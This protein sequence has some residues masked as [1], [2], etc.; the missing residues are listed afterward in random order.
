MWIL[1]EAIL[2]LEARDLLGDYKVT[3]KLTIYG[4]LHGS[5][6]GL[7]HPEVF[8]CTLFLLRTVLHNPTAHT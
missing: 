7:E 8:V 1:V 4:F 2:L 6:E 3:S 5:L